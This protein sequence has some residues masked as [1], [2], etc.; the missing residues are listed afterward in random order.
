MAATT[1]L[2][3]ALYLAEQVRQLERLAIERHGLSG[4]ELMERAGRFA[5]DTL[6]VR[7][8]RAARLLV[9][10][11]P[12][13]NG[14]D[15]Y[16]VARL[17]RE[18]GLDPRVAT[19]GPGPEKGEAGR[20]RASCESSG[21]RTVPFTP[22]LLRDV[23]M[24]VDAWLGTG[25]DRN[26]SGEWRTAVET[27]NGARR[28]VLALDVP[29]GLNSDSGRV[30]GAAVR[31]CATVSF[32]GL[33]AG[34][35]TG[36]GREYAGD[37][38]FHDLGVP[39][40]AYA[41]IEPFARR[42]TNASVHGLLSR[43]E[44]HAHKGSFGR[45]LVVGGAPGM[46]GAARLCGEGAARAGAGMVMLA[47]HPDHAALIHAG[48]P[49]LMAHA[50]RTAAALKKLIERAT[51]VALGPGLGREAWGKRLFET[52]LKATH[53]L[54]VDA[55]G[56]FFFLAGSRKRRA[57]WV[58]TPHSGEAARLLKCT[59][60]EIDADRFAAARK[61]STGFGGV[62]VLK[63]AGTLI[64]DSRQ[65]IIHVCDRGNPGMASGGMGDVLAG[66][67]AGLCAQGLSPFNAARLGVW[68][69]A[70]AGDAVAGRHGEVGMLASDLFPAIRNT[71]NRLA[72]AD[73]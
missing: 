39:E 26:L 62:C 31:A 71:L 24:I 23:D 72:G 59:V 12:G 60:D 3:E 13:K 57:D 19:L 68:V 34:M 54:V 30:M 65:S 50:V 70:T 38:H 40:T 7:W 46:P 5:C 9:L 17:A 6:R 2:P 55:D 25:L 61:I 51:V 47:T 20:A 67:I 33:K 69:H 42:I 29:T 15:G 16:A 18:Q 36:A 63:G 14:G 53:P 8:P 1:T 22:D 4:A 41:M 21:V 10:C 45:V 43:R 56:L 64:A 52:T 48:R 58:L 37:I 32:V 27:V 11:G 44:R 28:P 49:E 66:V 35:F 73:G